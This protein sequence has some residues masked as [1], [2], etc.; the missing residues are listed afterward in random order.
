MNTHVIVSPNVLKQNTS[1]ETQQIDLG[2]LRDAINQ[3]EIHPVGIR[4]RDVP[5]AFA[6]RV[7]TCGVLLFSFCGGN[8]TTI[9]LHL[10]MSGIF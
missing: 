7:L 8:I 3:S 5:S 9:L 1:A 2:D 10:C 4:S 6:L